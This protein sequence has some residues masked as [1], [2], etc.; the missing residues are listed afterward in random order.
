MKWFVSNKKY[1]RLLEEKEN[2]QNL[3]NNLRIKF[4]SLNEE[5]CS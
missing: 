2:L 4:I 1:K 5:Y 3:Y